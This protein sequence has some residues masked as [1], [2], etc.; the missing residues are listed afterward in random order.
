MDLGASVVLT[1]LVVAV[2]IMYYDLRAQNRDQRGDLAA[3]AERQNRLE[4]AQ[5]GL[6]TELDK[7]AEDSAN[8]AV[9]ANAAVHT[10][11]RAEER[12]QEAA[13]RPGVALM[14]SPTDH[15]PPRRPT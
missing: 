4:R 11:Q 10:A 5:R 14:V 6:V 15:G 3:L 8:L 12:V 13:S 2:A 7:V 1:F 9:K